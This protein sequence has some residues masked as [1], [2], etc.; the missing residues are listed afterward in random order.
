M[1]DAV[2]GTW[3]FSLVITFTLI[4]TAFLVL[5]L[6]YSKAYKV[7][8]EM[9]SMIEKYEGLTTV[10][11]TGMDGTGTSYHGLGSI[12]IM[13]LYLKNNNYVT[14]G[15]CD[16]GDYATDD[17]DSSTLIKVSGSSSSKYFYCISYK[18]DSECKTIFRITVFYDFNLPVLGKLRK[19]SISGQTN[20][21]YKAY[22]PDGQI[23]CTQ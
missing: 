10:S 20:E 17:L 16:A 22:L 12:T 11:R 9:T 1:R 2:G 21:I 4:F 15:T 23:G 6:A 7:K 18:S 8:N 3:I 19:F 14:K 5:S 13:N